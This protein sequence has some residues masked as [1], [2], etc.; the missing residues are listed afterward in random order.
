MALVIARDAARG[1]VVSYP[2]PRIRTPPYRGG[3]RASDCA[4][5]VGVLRARLEQPEDEH[6]AAEVSGP[7]RIPRGP[8]KSRC[9]ASRY[10]VCSSWA[11]WFEMGFVDAISAVRVGAKGLACRM[12]RGMP[13]NVCTGTSLRSI[14]GGIASLLLRGP[15]ICKL[16]DVHAGL[17]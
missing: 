16:D 3:G 10:V 1:V 9:S 6:F 11:S 2:S 4:P 12:P 5:G 17:A 15:A 14:G 13:Y 8:G 7:S